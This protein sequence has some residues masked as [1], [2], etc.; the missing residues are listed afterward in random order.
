[1]PACAVCVVL[2]VWHLIE[3]HVLLCLHTLIHSQ[4]YV[5]KP[6]L[7]ILLACLGVH[8]DEEVLTQ[9]NLAFMGPLKF[10]A[11]VQVFSA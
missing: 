9:N 11:K 7:R 10:F 3:L 2:H 6:A 4:P 5:H 1:M 8:A